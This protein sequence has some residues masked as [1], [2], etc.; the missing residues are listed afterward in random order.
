MQAQAPRVVV[1]DP[2]VDHDYGIERQIVSAYGAQLVVPSHDRAST[3]ELAN[4]DVILVHRGPVDASIATMATRCRGYVVYGI[5]TDSVDAG[6]AAG[7]GAVVRGVP[8]YC[9]D[10][11]A[12]HAL[13][14][15]LA[16]ER[17]VVRMA[18]I[19]ANGG[20]RDGR[21]ATPIRRLRGQTMSIIGAGSIGR[22]IAR[23][24]QAFGFRTLAFD[25]FVETTD[26]P[27]LTLTSFADALAQADV[28]VLSVPLTETTER[29]I[30]HN[31]FA[32][33][34]STCFLVN[35]ARGRVVDEVALSEALRTGRI[36]GAALDV[37]SQEPPDPQAD[38]LWGCPNLLMTPHQGATSVE[39]VRDLQEGAAQTAVDILAAR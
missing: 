15:V 18:G 3:A 23:R 29:M 22:G 17:Q 12:D 11:V 21:P 36:A 34:K 5:G 27:G 4:A 33:L 6:A 8:G 14:L 37:R 7:R 16:L 19:T 39:S 13:A 24:A 35:V 25:P 10:E 9:R 1:F 2:Q 28:L 30:D 26:E 38:P 20:W 32:S 31:A